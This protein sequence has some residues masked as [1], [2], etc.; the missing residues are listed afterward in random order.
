MDCMGIVSGSV[1]DC[2]ECAF[3]INKL[4]CLVH[5]NP[6]DLALLLDVGVKCT[7]RDGLLRKNQIYRDISDS[8]DHDSRIKSAALQICT[9][10]S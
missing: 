8:A 3:A 10:A 6:E 5:G 1:E 7:D 4:V 9:R 2:P